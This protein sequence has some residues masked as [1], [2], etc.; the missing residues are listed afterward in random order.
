M[1]H[2]V[3]FALVLSAAE[4]AGLYFEQTTVVRLAGA[5]AGPGVR[6][7]V[8]HAGRRLRLEAG[9]SAGGPA[10]VLRLDEGRAF[11]LDPEAKVAVELDASRL[12][13]RSHQDASV[14]ASLMGGEDT[15][16]SA[17]LEGTRTIAGHRCRGFRLRGR[18]GEP[19]RLGRR[20]RPGGPGVF[21]DFLEWSGAAQALGGLVAAIRELPGFPLETRTRVS[22][23]GET[24]E[25]I[26]TVT[27]DPRRPAAGGA[28]RGA[29]GLARRVRETLNDGGLPDEDPDLDRRQR[30]GPLRHGLRRAR[31]HASRGAGCSS[32]WRA[33][34]SACST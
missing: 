23:L 4:P 14:A 33:P 10:L 30:R 31:H 24:Q 13:A 5:V 3:V 25:T 6:S 19:R 28:V 17:P 2:A 20:G 22:V 12:R 7:R 29:G 32:W 11:R 26:A 34:S 21:A 27:A 16:R 15:L 1:I 9:D 8:W 18:A